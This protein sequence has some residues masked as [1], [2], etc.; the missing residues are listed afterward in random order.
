MK[1][2]AFLFVVLHDKNLGIRF[3][4]Q[5]DFDYCKS[6]GSPGQMSEKCRIHEKAALILKSS[7]L[8]G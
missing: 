2:C 7:S 3:V 4:K 5:T 8:S 1:S 6:S